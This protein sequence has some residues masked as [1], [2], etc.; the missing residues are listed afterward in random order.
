MSTYPTKDELS[1]D[2]FRRALSPEIIAIVMIV[3]VGVGGIVAVASGSSDAS[4]S[5]TA[6]PVASSGSVTPTASASPTATPRLVVPTLTIGSL[7]P[8]PRP[9]ATP[10]PSAS[11]PTWSAAARAL[12]AADVRLI[13]WRESLRRELARPPERS[14]ELAHLLRSTNL[15]ITTASGYVDGLEGTDAPDAIVG[16]LRSVHETALEAGL[17]TLTIVLQDVQAYRK[18]T[19]EVIAAL[20]PLESELQTL[21]A[22][23]GLPDP[24]PELRSSPAPSASVVP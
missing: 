5:P 11:T 22:S 17:R 19:A 4:G 15:A 14:D 18:G 8:T 2:R 1:E 10:S 3:I 7:P 12:I 20:E 24:L 21:A 16:T 9:T 23:A 13:E 6:S